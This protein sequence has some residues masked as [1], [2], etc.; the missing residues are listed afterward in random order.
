MSDLPRAA[1][2]SL[3][4]MQC[5]LALDLDGNAFE[6]QDIT[7]ILQL[8]SLTHLGVP[9]VGDSI[10][11]VLIQL[12]SSLPQLSSL[13]VRDVCSPEATQELAAL[14]RLTMLE[15]VG[16]EPT[17]Q[18][19]GMLSQLRVL[20]LSDGDICTVTY[21]LEAF[22][23][24][25]SLVSLQRSAS[26]FFLSVAV[27]D[28]T[29]STIII[30]LVCSSDFPHLSEMAAILADAPL[31]VLEQ[32]IIAADKHKRRWLIGVLENIFPAA[33]I[34][35]DVV[36]TGARLDAAVL[37]K[38]VACLPRLQMLQLYEC[39]VGGV[40]EAAWS[41]L[42]MHSPHTIVADCIPTLSPALVGRLQAAQRAHLFEAE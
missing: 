19:T 33:Q 2:P 26:P 20:R 42:V 13:R 7:S 23:P 34:I 38:V 37:Q 30:D 32:V 9:R 15:G 41:A 39:R 4:L 12:S 28:P 40:P 1:L 24:L 27:Q 29:A 16:F 6:A 11:Q 14:S 17:D 8:R 5:L 31:F 21:S 35:T 36:I 18:C 22:M 25:Q 3:A 10:Q